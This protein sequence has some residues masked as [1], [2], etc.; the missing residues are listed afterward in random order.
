MRVL[1]FPVFVGNGVPESSI[2]SPQ[3]TGRAAA[4]LM[5]YNALAPQIPQKNAAA[6]GQSLKTG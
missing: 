1:R 3:S 5:L 6:L 4:D 2:C